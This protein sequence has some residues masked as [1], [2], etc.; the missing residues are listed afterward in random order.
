MAWR[1]NYP[2][3][4][5]MS[6][7][8]FFGLQ[9]GLN[10]C[11]PIARREHQNSLPRDEIFFFSNFV[12]SF[13]LKFKNMMKVIIKKIGEPADRKIYLLARNPVVKRT[14]S[15]ITIH[16]SLRGSID[17]S[18]RRYKAPLSASALPSATS[19]SL[20]PIMRV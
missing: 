8:N 15:L 5:K 17:S 6:A 10:H 18:S 16:S 9:G 3:V 19:N 7:M 1:Q 4:A 20:P 11:I 2:A 13:N 14:Y 12:H